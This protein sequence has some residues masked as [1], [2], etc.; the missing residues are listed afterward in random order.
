MVQL[1]K[2]RSLL[3]SKVVVVSCRLTCLVAS[4]VIGI[5]SSTVEVIASPLIGR[6]G[7]GVHWVLSV[8]ISSTI[9]IVAMV[10]CVGSILNLSSSSFSLSHLSL[11]LAIIPMFSLIFTWIA[12]IGVTFLS[13]RGEV[14]V[15]YLL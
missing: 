8:W 4:I 10:W 1:S 7:L 14:H 3:S 2:S 13:S 6:I 5:S 12:F 15:N 9:W 11:S